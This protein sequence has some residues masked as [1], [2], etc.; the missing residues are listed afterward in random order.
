MK[1]DGDKLNWELGNFMCSN[2]SQSCYIYSVK[3][4]GDTD[5]GRMS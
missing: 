1:V 5:A 4:L 3:A 2:L